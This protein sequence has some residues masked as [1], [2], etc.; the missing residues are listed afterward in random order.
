M[1]KN[2]IIL[3]FFYLL[4]TGCSSVSR[5]SDYSTS[6]LKTL[7][8][9]EELGY[10]FDKACRDKCYLEQVRTSS[11]AFADCHCEQD[12]TADSITSVLYKAVKSYYDG[13]TKL[14]VNKLTSYKTQALARE[15][16][17]GKFGDLKINKA[18]A[19]AYS[20][21]SAL[22]LNAITESYRRKK[23]KVFIEQA[24]EPVQVLISA[25]HSNLASNLAGKINVHKERLQSIYH[26][27]LQDSTSSEYEK[28]KIIDDF[29]IQAEDLD[30]QQKQL[31]SF[32]KALKSISAGHQK[33]YDHRNKINANEMKEMLAQYA[34]DLEDM[35]SDFNKLKNR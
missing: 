8:K 12:Q 17:S 21:L 4:I 1:N 23:I 31:I 28:K 25:L 3:L 13:L 35:I 32:G 22:L 14:S 7:K 26:N 20:K 29:T 19:D 6:A 30:L 10:T 24:N 5:I 16:A 11:L 27:F 34:S 18:E 9:Y 15:L 2:F 33:M